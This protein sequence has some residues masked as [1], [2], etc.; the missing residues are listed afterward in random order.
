M[1]Q[2]RV[3][4]RGA[5]FGFGLGGLALLR[6]GEELG[7]ALGAEGVLSRRGGGGEEGG[8]GGADEGVV[9]GTRGGLHEALGDL[10]GGGGREPAVR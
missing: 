7:E 6:G 9:G 1:I 2:E 8:E 3:N 10:R 5:G 4:E